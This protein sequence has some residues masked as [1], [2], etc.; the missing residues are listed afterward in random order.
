M[1]CN[2]SCRRGSD[3]TLL[4]LW[5]RPA[6]LIRPLAWELPHASD[7]ALKRQKK[8]RESEKES[9]REEGRKKGRKKEKPRT[10]FILMGKSV[11]FDML[12]T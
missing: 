7:V 2:V 5:C 10:D 1:S 8:E 4:W 3:P 11:M 9:G 6:T 12:Q